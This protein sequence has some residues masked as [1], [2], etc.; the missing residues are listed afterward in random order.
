MRDDWS[1]RVLTSQSCDLE[2]LS[3][4]IGE[5]VGMSLMALTGLCNATSL[6]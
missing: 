6:S 3:Q 5:V 2:K 1:L 4:I